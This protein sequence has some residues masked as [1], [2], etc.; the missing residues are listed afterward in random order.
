[1]SIR[2][3]VFALLAVVAGAVACANPLALDDAV[4]V[5]VWSGPEDIRLEDGTTY[6]HL[7]DTLI[8]RSDYTASY[9]HYLLVLTPDDEPP[10]LVVTNRSGD[11]RIDGRVVTIFHIPCRSGACSGRGSIPKFRMFGDVLRLEAD[12]TRIFV[13]Q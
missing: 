1:M 9:K 3:G 12:S 13:R 5:Y 7:A 11:Y 6:R 4:G 2:N 8:L 10:T